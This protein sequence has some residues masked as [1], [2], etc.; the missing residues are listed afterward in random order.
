M[1]NKGGIVFLI[2]AFGFILS[3]SIISYAGDNNQIIKKEKELEHRE[4]LNRVIYYKNEQKILMRSRRNG[5][6]IQR[7]YYK[8]SPVAKMVVFFNSKKELLESFYLTIFPPSGVRV[9]ISPTDK[10]VKKYPKVHIEDITIEKRDNPGEIINMFKIESE[11]G[12]LV[13]L[14]EKEIQERTP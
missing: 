4:D 3:F 1:K 8:D 7:I 9:S 10:S 2:L 5:V 11:T 13:P 12:I 14:S 6:I